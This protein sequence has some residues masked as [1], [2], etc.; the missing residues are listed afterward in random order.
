MIG[1]CNAC[2]EQHSCTVCG[3]PVTG[4]DHVGVRASSGS[5]L[6]SGVWHIASTCGHA[7][8]LDAPAKSGQG[9]QLAV[10]EGGPLW[11]SGYRWQSIYWG[12]YWQ[13]KTLPF[14]TAQ[15]DKAVADIEADSSYWGGLSEYN[16]GRGTINASVTINTD[17]PASID[18]SQIGPQISAWIRGGV[19]PELGA[20]GAYNIFFPPGVTVT[21]QGSASCTQFCDFH[22]YDGTHF[23]T[24]EPY[25]CSNG[26]NQCTSNDFDTLTQGLSEE[27]VELAT[28]M[29]PGT[30]WVIGSEE[31]CDH[32]DASFI[33]RQITEGEYVNAWYSDA[34]GGCWAPSP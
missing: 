19:I 23:Y 34:K 17:P 30:G 11:K 15:V 5:K 7:Q 9:K 4:F 13:R 28:D 26:C 14:S 1:T 10:Y 31:V 8:K 6:R 27:M 2:K 33:C 3:Q 16:V 24:V 29:N 22:D 32:C 25:P 21:L 12:T 20:Q 18:D